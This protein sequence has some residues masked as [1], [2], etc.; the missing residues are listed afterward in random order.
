MSETAFVAKIRRAWLAAA[1]R[2]GD[3]RGIRTSGRASW[4][5]AAYR[6]ATVSSRASAW[7][8]NDLLSCGWPPGPRDENECGCHHGQGHQPHTKRAAAHGRPRVGPGGDG[9]GGREGGIGAGRKSER[10]PAPGAAPE[11]ALFGL[12]G[13]VNCGNT[14]QSPSGA[15][16]D[17]FPP[18]RDAPPRSHDRHE[19]TA[20][21]RSPGRVRSFRR[22]TQVA[23]ALG[24][25]RHEPHRPRRRRASRSTR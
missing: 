24:R 19:Y 10:Y 3:V 2:G 9:E 4:A 22:R 25:T 16:R 7:A 20:H 17:Q 23:G 18:V 21:G 14:R 11:S 5:S 12:W 13:Q 8:R 6:L 15:G 1:S